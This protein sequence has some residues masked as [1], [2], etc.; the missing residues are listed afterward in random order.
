MLLVY[1]LPIG[2]LTS[3]SVE[4]WLGF[5]KGGV[6]SV[7]LSISVPACAS[8]ISPSIKKYVHVFVCIH[9]YLSIYMYM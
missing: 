9:T 8:T 7:D 6:D 3:P 4:K 5:R 1:V 2:Y